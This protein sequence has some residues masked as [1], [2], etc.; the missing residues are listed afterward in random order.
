MI[1]SGANQILRKPASASV[2]AGILHEIAEGKFL[3]HPAPTPVPLEAELHKLHLEQSVAKLEAKNRRLESSVEQ[4]TLDHQHLGQQLRQAQSMAA[5]GT[6]A[7]SIAH[8]FNNILA[9]IYQYCELARDEAHGNATLTEHLNGLSRGAT[10]ATALVQ[11]IFAFGCKRNDT[12]RPLELWQVAIEAAGLL[13][14]AVP[15]TIDVQTSFGQDTPDVFANATEIHQILMNLGINAAH[16]MRALGGRLTITLENCLVD[17]KLAALHS[18][19]R[20]GHYARLTVS[21]TGHGMDEQT[22]ARIF[23]PFF[24]TKASGEGTGLGLAIVRDIVR[25]SNCAITVS[26]R[27]GEGTTFR[28]YFPAHVE[29]SD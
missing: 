14:A 28:V 18:G 6:L 4:L 11:Q 9:A 17:A 26:S 2:F 27:L 13:R 10:R 25:S 23:E 3:P 24:T 29:I 12:R 21:D 7:M 5:L 22:L 15:A 20:A 16:A 1:E 19:L 8:D